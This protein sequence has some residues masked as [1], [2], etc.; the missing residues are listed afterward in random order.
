MSE[1]ASALITS[2]LT[3]TG[4]TT[5]FYELKLG[6]RNTDRLEVHLRFPEGRAEPEVIQLKKDD[7][8]ILSVD[9]MCLNQ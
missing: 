7:S 1:K 2:S 9:F 6:M 4:S 8:R 3:D 5:E